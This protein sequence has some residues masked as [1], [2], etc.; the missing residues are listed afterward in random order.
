MTTSHFWAW[1]E[2]LPSRSEQTLP[3]LDWLSVITL[4]AHQ[5]HPGACPGSILERVILNTP[6]VKG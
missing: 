3:E 2:R 1:M 4:C 5:N 6:Q